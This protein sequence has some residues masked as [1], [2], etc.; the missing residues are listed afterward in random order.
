ML[1][2]ISLFVFMLL[3]LSCTCG[4]TKQNLHNRRDKVTISNCTKTLAQPELTYGSILKELDTALE[5]P[6]VSKPI[7][8][9]IL[10]RDGYVISYNSDTRNCNWVAYELTRDEANGEVPRDNN[11]Y[12]DF[13]VATPRATK[14][15]YKGSGWSRGHM[16]PAGDMKWSE[17]AMYQSCLFTNICP[18]DATLNNGAWESV[19]RQCR[20]LAKQKGQVYIVCG[21]LY[22]GTI[23]TIGPNKIR[24]PDS[25]FKVILVPDE[26]SYLCIGF[27]FPNEQITA[28]QKNNYA[29]S[30]DK[31]EE[32]CG[33]DFF[34]KLPD[35]IEDSIE[36]E[37]SWSLLN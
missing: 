14:D 3:C 5:I 22:N 27:I 16:A 36:S 32:I 9:Q 6:I 30:V 1:Y 23:R 25:F 31:V 28:A 15:D 24:I 8:S 37:I 7:S 29:F 11:F 13:D 26:Q 33:M 17:N 20:S 21:P 19:E 2:K 12:E 35:I 4:N 18:Q 34:S 10:E